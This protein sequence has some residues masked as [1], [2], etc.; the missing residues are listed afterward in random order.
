[1]NI[2]FSFPKSLARLILALTLVATANGLLL[3]G[4]VHIAHASGPYVVNVSYD[5]P[6][7]NLGNGI[8]YDGVGGCTLRAA[9]QQASA[10]G[11]AT[12]ITFDASLAGTT[13]NLAGSYGTI[14]WAGSN[15]YLNGGEAITVSGE[16]MNVGQS[17]FQIQGDDNTVANLAIKNS[18]RD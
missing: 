2:H 4:G 7:S 12:N 6:D 11:G 10:D 15:I 9:I 1:M 18:R 5:G 8:C 13:I 14:I 3:P 16:F 17:M